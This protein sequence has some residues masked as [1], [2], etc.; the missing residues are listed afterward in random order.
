MVTELWIG[1]GGLELA[2]QLRL[3][4]SGKEAVLVALTSH[5]QAETQASALAAGFDYFL[6]KPVTIDQVKAVFR[7]IEY[8]LQDTGSS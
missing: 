5:V 2:K 6:A 1:G 4:P 7:C 3:L 8:R